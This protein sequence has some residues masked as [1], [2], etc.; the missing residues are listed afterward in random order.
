MNPV[1]NKKWLSDIILK[2]DI[3][4]L[5][6]L[7]TSHGKALIEAA[8]DGKLWELWY[9]S[10]PSPNTINSYIDQALTTAPCKHRLSICG[11]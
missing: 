4:R 1:E 2:G 10:I 5:E 7:K 9:T 8:S 11:D 3:V 6:L